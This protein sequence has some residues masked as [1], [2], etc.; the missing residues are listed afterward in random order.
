MEKLEIN[1][2]TNSWKRVVMIIEKE[3]NKKDVLDETRGGRIREEK[4]E[5]FPVVRY[6]AWT[7]TAL[8]RKEL[9]SSPPLTCMSP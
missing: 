2:Y 1:N 8:T 4:K 3:K 5:S 9:A 6:C 7:Q